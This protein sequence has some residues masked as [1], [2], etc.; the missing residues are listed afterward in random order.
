MVLYRDK[1]V[2][3]KHRIQHI[4]IYRNKS[5]RPLIINRFSSSP[6][7]SIGK[8]QPDNRESGGENCLAILNNFYKDGVKWHD[9]GCSHEKSIICEKS[10]WPPGKWTRERVNDVLPNEDVNVCITVMVFGWSPWLLVQRRII[11]NCLYLFLIYV[12]AGN[13]F[14]FALICLSCS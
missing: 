13:K 10:N 9:V 12:K 5:W 2:I 1:H 3:F 14:K 11:G 6:P 8:R 7:T 4:S